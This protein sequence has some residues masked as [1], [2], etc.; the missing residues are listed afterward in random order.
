MIRCDAKKIR[1]DQEFSI[2]LMIPKSGP[3]KIF[4]KR[5]QEINPKII[6]K[7]KKRNKKLNY[8]MGMTV[9][10]LL[11]Q[12]LKKVQHISLLKLDTL[13]RIYHKMLLALSQ[14]CLIMK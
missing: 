12:P 6:K 1:Q 8:R 9:L 7:T 5:N 11:S 10:M 13:L 14:I 4:L 3:W 2:S